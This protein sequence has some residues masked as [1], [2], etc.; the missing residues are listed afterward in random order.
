MD[1]LLMSVDERLERLKAATD[2]IHPSAGFE[3]RVMAA[4]AQLGSADWRTSIWRAGRYWL[5]A[6]FVMV[7]LST[8][9]AVNRV[10]RADDLTATT[11]GTVEQEW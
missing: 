2:A 6:S 11:Y 8:L 7:A 3:N 4:V 9:L 10:A 1:E 5:L